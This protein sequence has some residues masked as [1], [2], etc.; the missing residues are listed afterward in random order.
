MPVLSLRVSPV[1][2]LRQWRTYVWIARHLVQTALRALTP[3]DSPVAI[4]QLSQDASCSSESS[5]ET[6]N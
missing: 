5:F 1:L 2:R 4:Y 3:S 6:T